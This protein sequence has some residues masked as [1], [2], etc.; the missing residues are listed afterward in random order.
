MDTGVKRG[1]G[2]ALA[3]ALLWGLAAV[4]VLV[5]QDPPLTVETM[6]GLIALAGLLGVF[7]GL[8]RVAWVLLR[9]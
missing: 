2:M 7:A 9:R 1:L 3:G 4:V 8:G 6:F 5:L